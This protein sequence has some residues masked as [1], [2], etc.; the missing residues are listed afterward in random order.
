MKIFV[1]YL[2]VLLLLIPLA[3]QSKA[4]NWK[5]SG[6]TKTFILFQHPR[7]DC[8]DNWIM[9]DPWA[10]KLSYVPRDFLS[11][12]LAYV[13]SPHWN[14]PAVV[15]DGTGTTSLSQ[16]RF[17][18][19]DQRLW[20]KASNETKK[21]SLWHNLDRAYVRLSTGWADIFA[22]RQPIAWG[23]ARFINP[24][25]IIAPYG[26]QELDT[27]DRIGV[28][29]VKMNIP[30]GQMSEIGLGFIAGK[31]LKHEN[32]VLFL[33]PKLYLL[34]TDLAL[35][36]MEFQRDHL[37][38]FDLARAIGGAGI[39]FEAGYMKFKVTEETGMRL[40]SGADYRLSDKVYVF[41]E[42]HF[43]GFGEINASDYFL[44]YS[45]QAYLENT[46]YLSAKNYL[47]LGINYQWTPLL[48]SGTQPIL[49]LNDL[50]VMLNQQFEYNLTQ[51][52]YLAFGIFKGFGKESELSSSGLL[53]ARSEFGSYSDIYYFSYR[54]YF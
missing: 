53:L 7:S 9:T 29:A 42:Y 44:N 48:N 5:F 15:F 3:K 20:P 34:K 49:N 40:S 13:T 46:V 27:E 10:F 50:S 39:W 12:N 36:L 2:I 25:D 38:G 22:G 52:S 41:G 24:T 47:A 11:F 37:L 1:K 19:F 51:N 17:Q 35:V 54:K 33:R 18:D 32:S 31:D 14:S 28:D 23:S 30:L 8:N 6:Y 21:L 26:F 45:K 4:D 43:N 16:Y